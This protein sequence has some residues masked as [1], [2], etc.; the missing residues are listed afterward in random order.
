MKDKQALSRWALTNGGFA[1][2]SALA[3]IQS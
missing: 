3:Q 1:E 2:Q